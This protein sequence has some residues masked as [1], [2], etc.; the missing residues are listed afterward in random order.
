MLELKLNLKQCSLSGKIKD[1]H[2]EGF[3]KKPITVKKGSQT[4]KFEQK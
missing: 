3:Y 1:A 4:L 2:R